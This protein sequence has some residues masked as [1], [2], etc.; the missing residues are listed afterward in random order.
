[1]KRVNRVI[2]LLINCQLFLLSVREDLYQLAH[3]L[4]IV[5]DQLLV[6]HLLNYGVWVLIYKH[7]GYC[8]LVTCLYG[9]FVAIAL[10]HKQRNV[11]S[12]LQK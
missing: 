1:M 3:I 8:L 9:T 7:T 5:H 4:Q 6:W 12:I 11:D 2:Q 10:P